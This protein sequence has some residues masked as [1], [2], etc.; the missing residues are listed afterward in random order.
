M[1]GELRLIPGAVDAEPGAGLL[2][3][4][5]AEVEAICGVAPDAPHMPLAGPAELSPPHGAFLIGTI[6]GEPVCC[7]GLK[8]LDDRACEIKRMYVMPAARGRG[9]AR[10]LLAGLEDH[11]RGLGYELARLDT[12]GRLPNAVALYESAGYRPI[13]NF[14]GNPIATYFGEKPLR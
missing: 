9:V 11:A 14:N 10:R 6:D 13:P 7:G 8:R 4:M 3:A 12:D 1:T 2:A 5:H